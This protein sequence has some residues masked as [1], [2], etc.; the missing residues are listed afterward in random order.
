MI[1]PVN[2]TSSTTAKNRPWRVGR[3]NTRRCTSTITPDSGPRSWN[4]QLMRRFLR[5]AY[6]NG[7]VMGDG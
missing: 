7:P 6:I 3:M 4:S 5:T 1:E 2:M